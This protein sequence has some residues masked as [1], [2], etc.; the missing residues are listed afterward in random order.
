MRQ[1]VPI[2]NNNGQVFLRFDFNQGGAAKLAKVTREA[3]G[4]YLIISAQGKLIAVPRIAAI[5]D[6][7]SFPLPVSNVEEA[8][9][10][11]QLIR[12]PA[13]R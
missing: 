1:I 8:Q 4:N 7:A 10:I 6:G 3:Q 13:G 2:R 11:T 9:A 12:Q 5:Y